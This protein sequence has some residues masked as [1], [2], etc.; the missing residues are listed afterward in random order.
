VDPASLVRTR[1]SPE[2][3]MRMLLLGSGGG[4]G[5]GPGGQEA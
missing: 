5:R 3:A 2:E 4:R 1:L